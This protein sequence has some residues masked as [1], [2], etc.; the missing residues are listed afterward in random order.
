MS[1]QTQSKSTE[2]GPEVEVVCDKCDGK[3]GLAVSTQAAS[4][5]G[6][7][8]TLS[9]KSKTP[10]A[11]KTP[12]AR[13][14]LEAKV[15]QVMYVPPKTPRPPTATAKPNPFTFRRYEILEKKILADESDI[16]R[17]LTAT[18]KKG[19]GPV[20]VKADVGMNA[21]LTAH[22]TQK[23]GITGNMAAQ[24]QA[25]FVGSLNVYKQHNNRIQHF[26]T[27]CGQLNSEV[28]CTAIEKLCVRERASAKERMGSDSS[29]P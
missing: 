28:F 11:L 21:F 5:K 3:G 22:F 6:K 1:G 4:G 7:R 17:A 23:F 13:V 24:Q 26:L 20:P 18:P 15:L 27:L 14:I 9:P 12:K 8:E 25:N 29:A 16:V 10:R 19:G 2:T